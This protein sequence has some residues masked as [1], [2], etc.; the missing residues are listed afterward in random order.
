MIVRLTEVFGEH[1]SKPSKSRSISSMLLIDTPLSQHLAHKSRRSSVASSP[2][3]V[4]LSNAVE[5][6]LKGRSLVR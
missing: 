5:S 6:R 4:M 3:S 2:Y 1:R